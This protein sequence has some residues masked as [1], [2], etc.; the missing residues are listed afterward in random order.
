MM[1]SDFSDWLLTFGVIVGCV[2]V[3]V[4]LIEAMFRRPTRR[5]RMTWPYALGSLV[6]LVL[7][8]LNTFVHTRDA[9]TSVVPSGLVL[10]AATVLVL[11]VTGWMTRQAYDAADTE[12]IA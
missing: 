3:V 4:A 9:W 11:I 7:A 6:T 8:T 12:V 1:W 10:S 2:A 5:D